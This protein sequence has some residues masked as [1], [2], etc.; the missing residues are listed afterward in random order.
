MLS[1]R[2]P[3][4]AALPSCVGPGIADN[5]SR[6]TASFTDW[7]MACCAG[8]APASPRGTPGCSATKNHC[9]RWRDGREAAQLHALKPQINPESLEFRANADTVRALVE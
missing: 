8:L 1:S 6:C 5:V 4:S 9:E 7:T 3:M 2:S